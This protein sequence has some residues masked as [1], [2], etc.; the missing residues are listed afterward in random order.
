MTRAMKK[1]D[2]Q[3][4]RD[5]LDELKW[6]SRVKETEIG[7]EVDAGVVTLTGTVDSWAT[8]L[9]AREAVHRVTGV[10]DVA[11]DIRVKPPGTY[12]RTDTEIAQAV[13]QALEW[14]V[15][16][17]D[18]RIRTTVSNGAVTL[19]GTVETWSQH[20]DA[21]RC[22]RNLAGVR[23]V[24]NLIEVRPSGPPVSPLAV[25]E[26]IEQA[27]DRHAVHAAKRVMISVDD[28]KVTLAGSVPSWAERQAIEGAVKG[29]PGVGK[30]D[31][32]LV[33]RS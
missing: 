22:V 14:D 4:H 18:D 9:A 8:R 28:G 16:V 13:R 33:I 25:R 15:L 3:I 17:P 30:V 19:E 11:D 31:D 6:N 23:E 24:T 26:A 7:V 1:T 21:A 10:L 12:E 29:T 32:Q 2:S 27:L 20:N 5:V